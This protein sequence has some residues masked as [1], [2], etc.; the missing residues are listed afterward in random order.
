MLLSQAMSLHQFQSPGRGSCGTCRRWRAWQA[1]MTKSCCH[2]CWLCAHRSCD[3]LTCSAQL[4]CVEPSCKRRDAGTC[5][6]FGRAM[7]LPPARRSEPSVLVF[8]LAAILFTR[9]VSL[10]SKEFLIPD[11]ALADG[12]PPLES[13]WR[14][15]PCR[16]TSCRYYFAHFSSDGACSCSGGGVLIG[17]QRSRRAV[18]QSSPLPRPCCAGWIVIKRAG[19][20]R[21]SLSSVRCLD[22]ALP[23]PCH[24]HTLD[25]AAIFVPASLGPQQLDTPRRSSRHG[26]HWTRPKRAAHE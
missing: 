12:V 18:P 1:E 16:R 3:L 23:A 22:Q 5:P 15:R 8:I 11:I 9:L 19:P 7:L 4:F 17:L 2:F 20:S 14:T 10:L 26:L 6:P 21:A 24:K 25:V 13:M